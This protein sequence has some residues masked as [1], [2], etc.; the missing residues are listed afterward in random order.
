MD[1]IQRRDGRVDGSKDALAATHSNG[2]PT[3]NTIMQSGKKTMTGRKDSMMETDTEDTGR[4][5]HATGTIRM[6]YQPPAV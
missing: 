4:E 2:A 5:S 3:S 1:Y 6:M